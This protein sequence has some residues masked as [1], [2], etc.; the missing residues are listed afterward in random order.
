MKPATLALAATLSAITCQAG[1]ADAT[2]P[3]DYTQRN[4][5]LTPAPTP[6]AE[7]KKPAIN[8]SVQE[9]RVEKPAV[10][11]KISPLRDRQAAVEVTEAKPKQVR[12]KDSHRPEVIEQEKS[13]F[14]HQTAAIATGSDTTKPPMVAR[15]QDSLTAATATNMA[16]FPAM[17]RGA[18]AKINRF[19]FRKNPPEASPVA[20]GV[21]VP[22]AGGS[23]LQK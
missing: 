8:S 18:T 7:K 9:K 11:K 17:D 4:G 16:R 12:E 3:I 13:R 5:A 6:G 19:V 15:Y 10:E 21:V 14:N 20:S 23:S 2:S 1:A 22:A